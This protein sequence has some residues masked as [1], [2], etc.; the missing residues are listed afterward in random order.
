MDGTLLDSTQ[1]LAGAWD[2][3]SQTYPNI[4]VQEI[5]SSAYLT[6]CNLCTV[7]VLYRLQ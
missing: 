7:V 1:G 5:L 6:G 2:T 3:F 4:N